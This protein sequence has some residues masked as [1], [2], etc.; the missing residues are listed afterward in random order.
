MPHSRPSKPE[1]KSSEQP[2]LNKVDRK[3]MGGRPPKFTSPSRP[4]TLTLP[5]STLEGLKQIDEDR[6][7]AIVKLTEAA[8]RT[9]TGSNPQVEIVK[10]ADNTGLLV[11]GPSKVLRRIAFLHLVEVA[12]A[13][14]VIAM[15]PGNDYRALE[16]ALID[17]LE[18]VP[19]SD[20]REHELVTKLLEQIKVLRKSAR[21]RMAEILFVELAQKGGRAALHSIMSTLGCYLG[22]LA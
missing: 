11:V 13:R 7:H 8:L 15:D 17:E 20:I 22:S 1:P 9:G 6:G 19:E 18:D 12:P 2:E 21:M 5:E 4:V 16:L 3:S 14:F 10:M